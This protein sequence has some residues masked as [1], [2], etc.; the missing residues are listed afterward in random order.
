ML[1]ERI[2]AHSDEPQL[3]A[4]LSEQLSAH[5]HP[6]YYGWLY[7]RNPHGSAEVWVLRDAAGTLVGAAAAFPRRIGIGGRELTAWNL[8]DFAVRADHR[9]LGPAVSLQR[10][11]LARVLGGDV[12]L[13]YDHPAQGMMAIYQRLGIA[14]AGQVVRFAK[15]LRIDPQVRRVLPEG[16]LSRAAS[17]VGNKLLSLGTARERAE[18]P[19][20]AALVG[21]FDD[22]VAELGSR[23]AGRFGVV[24]ART[25]DYLNWRYVDHPLLRHRIWTAEAGGRLAGYAVLLE[26]QG[27]AVLRDL[28]GEDDALD[29]LIAAIVERLRADGR[30]HALSLPTLATSPLVPLLTHWGFRVRETCPFV[31]C[32]R[33]GGPWDGTVTASENWFLTDG[34]RD[35]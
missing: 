18:A 22:R 16:V 29:A 27:H 15:P 23:L 31:V 1:V 6:D 9:S 3:R 25:P 2:E 32:T 30:A 8:G 28:F 24:G 5:R 17:A 10:A 19:L 35:V 20:V 14:A 4:F 11:C 33:R 34:D 21:R 12:A 7:R 13:A 26:D